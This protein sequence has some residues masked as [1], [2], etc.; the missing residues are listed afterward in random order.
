MKHKNTPASIFMVFSA[1]SFA[2]M[3]AVVKQAEEIPFIQ[4]V[5][6]RNLVMAVIMIPI[7]LG[8][9]SMGGSRQLI[10]GASGNRIRLIVRSV[11]GF[12]GVVLYFLSI[13]Q[14]QLGDS[15]LLNKLS[16]FFVIILSAVFLKEKILPYHI[17]AI[18]AA[19]CG[20][21]MIIKPGF[22]MDIFPAVA[23]LIA[24]LSGAAAYTIV[25]SLKGKEDSLTIICWF[26]V[27]SV[28]LSAVP[29]LIVW[30][31]PDAGELV[32]LL[33]TGVFAAGGQFFLTLAYI[34]G[35]AGEVSI[36]NYTQVV[37]AV[38]VGFILWREIPDLF[39]IG[40]GVLIIGSAVFLYFMRRR[41]EK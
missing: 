31:T 17:P 21:V 26:S 37:F 40:G 10:F 14:L 41:L 34:R 8:R 22:N 19:F 1:L 4:K 3:S 25:A 23:G 5:F 16:V 15:S 20:A 39:S 28:V 13:E 11:L 27:I 35:P 12:T 2:L 38:I 30:K 7:V 6:F 24:A 32:S 33:L 9:I 29:V 36:Y 18:I